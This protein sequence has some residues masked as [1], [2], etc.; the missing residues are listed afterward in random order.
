MCPASAYRR[1]AGLGFGLI[2]I[3]RRFGSRLGEVHGIDVKTV[4]IT[5]FTIVAA[6]RAGIQHAKIGKTRVTTVAVAIGKQRIHEIIIV[7]EITATERIIAI[8][9]AEFLRLRR[10]DDLADGQHD[11]ELGD[12]QDTMHRFADRW[13]RKC[14]IVAGAML[15]RQNKDGNATQINIGDFRSVDFQPG[16]I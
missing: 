8:T 12:L 14:H 6:I 3:G 2:T 11:V 1:P 10:A 7:P 13:Q 15:A 16:N 5:A 4:E 9:E